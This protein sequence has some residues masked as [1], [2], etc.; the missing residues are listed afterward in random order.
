MYILKKKKK[1]RSSEFNLILCLFKANF[2][3][4]LSVY[5]TLF[6]FSGSPSFSLVHKII[7]E[8]TPKA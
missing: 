8:A 6:H 3:F 2:D 5:I 1:N 7:Q 4:F